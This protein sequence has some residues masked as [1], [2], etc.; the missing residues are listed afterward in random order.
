[1]EGHDPGL[2]DTTYC[3][4][5][6]LGSTDLL[7]SDPSPPFT[8]Q[9]AAGSSTPF[10]F[11]VFGD[12]GQAYADGINADQANVLH[13]MSQSGARFAV[14]TG[15]TAYPGGGQ[16]DYGDLQQTG[17]DHE[18]RVRADVLGRAR[19]VDPA[20]STSPATTASPT[21]PTRS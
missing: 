12:W 7:G 18:Q 15:D 1:M 6:I 11:A 8:S 17:T 5:V 16:T 2:P 21:A 13:Q 9:V 3:Y 10:S 20:S 14:M 19:P 4:R